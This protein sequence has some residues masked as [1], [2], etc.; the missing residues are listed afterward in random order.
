MGISTNFILLYGIKLP[1]ISFELKEKCEAEF[2]HMV[3]SQIPLG[4]YDETEEYVAI[5]SSIV[6]FGEGSDTIVMKLN[7]VY[8]AH[9]EWDFILKMV[10]E[11]FGLEPDDEAQYYLGISQL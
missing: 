3:V 6:T 7:D 1:N 9:P 11:N 2:N 10:V 5:R 4:T 8:H